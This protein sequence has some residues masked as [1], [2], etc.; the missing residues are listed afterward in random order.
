MRVVAVTLLLN[1]I[2]LVI[3]VALLLGAGGTVAVSDGARPGDFLFPVDRAVE[4]AR[5]AFTPNEKKAELKIEFA[6][7]RLEEFN[8]IVDEELNDELTGALTEAEAGV[9]TNETIVKLEAGDAKAWFSTKVQTRE[10][11]IAEI[12]TR[13]GFAEAD[14]DAVLT[15]ETED[16]ASR[17]ED[18]AEVS[19]E[20]RLRLTNAFDVLNAFMVDAQMSASTSP[21]ILQALT[22][23]QASLLERS[24]DLPE[25]LRMRVEEDH[26]KFE[27]RS[28]NQRIKVEV[29]DGEVEIEVKDNDDDSDDSIDDSSDDS[30]SDDDSD[31]DSSGSGSNDDDSG[32]DS[33]GSGSGNDDSNDDS[34]GSGSGGDDSGDDSG[35]DDDSGSGS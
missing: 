26:E 13:Y 33:S 27:I 16:R 29:K 3:I 20:A 32:D 5:L 12:A 23:I 28:E 1:M 15:M 22:V 7:E 24:G 4:D 2:P 34:S 21:G 30:T 14:I 11:I 25:E 8:S 35:D 6:D 31:D 10:E 19:E 18:G 9:F 17:A